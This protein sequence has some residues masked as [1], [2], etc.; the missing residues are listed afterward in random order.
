VFFGVAARLPDSLR[1]RR[2]CLLLA[3]YFTIDEPVT[4]LALQQLAEETASSGPIIVLTE[5]STDAR[6]LQ[7]ALPLVCPALA[8][9]VRFMD[10]EMKAPGGVDQVVRSLRSFV[11]AGVMNRVVGLLD[12]DTAGRH[13]EI[14]LSETPL[15][16]N[17]RYCRRSSMRRAAAGAAR[18]S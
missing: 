1:L 15:P 14:Q 10:F 9:Y 16:P 17:F 12:N 13:A 2:T 11:A 8:G 3:E 7:L 4:R 6:F 18:C 5:G